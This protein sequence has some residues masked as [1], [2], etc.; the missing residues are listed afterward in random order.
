[1]NKDETFAKALLV[2]ADSKLLLVRKNGRSFSIP[3]D[4]IDEGADMVH[5]SRADKIPTT[6]ADYDTFTRETLKLRNVA[7]YLYIE[8]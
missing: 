3:F 4:S 2:A 5:R 6:Y 1:M 8:R 7:V